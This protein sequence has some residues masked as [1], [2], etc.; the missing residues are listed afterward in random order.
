LLLDEAKPDSPYYKDL[1][2]IVDQAD[3][4]KKIVG[5][6]LNFARKS[7]VNISQVKI[8]DLIKDSLRALVIPENI[9][10]NI[11]I[12]TN[13]SVLNCD[14]DQMVQ[15]F[16][17][18]IKNAIDAMPNGG[19][20]GITV[21]SSDNSDYN[22][23]FVISDTGTGISESNLK[24]MFEPFFTTK[25]DGKGTGLGMPIIYGIVKMHKGDIRVESNNNPENGTTGTSF[26]VSLPENKEKEITTMVG[27]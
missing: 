18:L 6:L 4:C 5:G 20:L 11:E 1:R 22:L 16:A 19:K 10:L 7:K 9:E 17:N 27:H 12:E 8:D 21:R 2:L 14:H 26:Y 3:R 13:N 23:V 15:V 25:E 24:R